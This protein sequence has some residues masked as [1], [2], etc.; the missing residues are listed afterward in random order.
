MGAESKVKAYGVNCFMKSTPAQCQKNPQKNTFS[1]HPVITISQ[2]LYFP[3]CFTG[4]LNKSLQLPL[5]LTV[6]FIYWNTKNELPTA[7]C[8]LTRLNF[9]QNYHVSLFCS[10]GTSNAS[11]TA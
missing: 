8:N 3:L 7:A 1:I 9:I 11:H 2:E 4:F 10:E 5:Q 6:T